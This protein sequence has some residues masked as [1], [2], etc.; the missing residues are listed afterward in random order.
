METGHELEI[1]EKG[2]EEFPVK[3][4]ISGNITMI[5]WIALGTIACGLISYV[6]A[7]IYLSAGFLMVYIVLRKLVC[8]NCYYY[9]KRCAT[10]WGR[11]SAMLF[12]KGSTGQ[13]SSC[14]G[15]KIAP[16][17]Y[18]CLLLVPLVLCIAALFQEITFGNIITLVLLLVVSVYSSLIARK[19]TCGNCRMRL[20]CPGSAVKKTESIRRNNASGL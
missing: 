11:L 3:N 8:A 15:V 5:L 13:Y 7:W 4:V 16:V 17:V 1:Y 19:E 20:I 12:S 9:G 10:G 2:L 14:A 6:G 18:A